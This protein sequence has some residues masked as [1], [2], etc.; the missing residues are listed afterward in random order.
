M[1]LARPA[2][3]TKSLIYQVEGLRART[4]DTLDYPMYAE[5]NT[6]ATAEARQ[7]AA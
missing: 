1:Q 4:R 3:T 5:R 6:R 7:K 2:D